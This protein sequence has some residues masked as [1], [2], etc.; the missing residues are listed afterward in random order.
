MEADEEHSDND[1]ADEH[2]LSWAQL[3]IQSNTE[4]AKTDHR[5]KSMT[6]SPSFI[7]ATQDTEAVELYLSPEAHPYLN[8]EL[9][10]HL[11]DETYSPMI[12]TPPEQ[13]LEPLSEPHIEPSAEQQNEMPSAT[14]PYFLAPAPI[15]TAGPL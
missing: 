3:W 8:P 4:M 10:P 12:L 6:E 2:V 7:V 14:V 15:S 13:Q 1:E 5:M 11:D 9:Q